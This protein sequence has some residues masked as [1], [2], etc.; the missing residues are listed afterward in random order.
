MQRVQR[1]HENAE[2]P[3]LQKFIFVEQ[4]YFSVCSFPV[5]ANRSMNRLTPDLITNLL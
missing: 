1:K 3:N 4:A 2:Q 5:F